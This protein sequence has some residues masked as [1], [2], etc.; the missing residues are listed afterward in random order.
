LLL[1]DYLHTGAC[2]QE[3]PATLTKILNPNPLYPRHFIQQVHQ[4][5]MKRS[6]ILPIL[7]FVHLQELQ[8]SRETTL[9]VHHPKGLLMLPAI[10]Q[11]E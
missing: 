6:L 5:A 11:K 1:A 4:H 8:Q 7:Y 2:R 3:P 9:F 10:E